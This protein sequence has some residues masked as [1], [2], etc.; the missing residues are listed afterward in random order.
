MLIPLKIVTEY[1]L[2]KSTIKINK[3]VKFLI[4]HNITACAI[5]DTNLY[6]VM[7]FYQEMTKNNLKPIIGL[8]VRVENY[9][10]YLY[11]KNANGY[12]NLLKIHTLKEKESLNFENL[13]SLLS[14]IKIVLP[15]E[16]YDLL[17]RFPNAYLSYKNDTEKIEALMNSEKSI[18]INPAH[19]LTKEN[20]EDLKYLEAI[21]KGI[22][23]KEVNTDY[24]SMYLKTNT[25]K[26]DEETSESFIS[27]IDIILENTS[28]YIPKFD[29]DIDSFKHLYN[30]TNKGLKKR[31]NNNVPEL[32]QK[33]LN[34]ELSVIK[35]MG[36]DDYFLIVYDYVLYAKKN[37]IL[38][39]P[40]RGSAAGSLVSYCL[41]ITD[42]DPIK[43]DLL[44]ERFL[45][46][47]RITMP[48][49]DIDFE[50]TKRGEVIEYVRKRYGENNVAPIM[51]FGTLGAKQV[52]RDVGRVLDMPLDLIDKFVKSLDA[53]L[54]LK[55][56][57]E[58]KPVHDFLKNYKELQKLYDIAYHLEGLKRHVST[59]AA[60]VV[61]SSIPL[62]EV[63]PI[64][65]NGEFIM[66]GLTME[67]LE[68]LGLLKMDFLALRNLTIISNVLE[69]I[70]SSTGKVL[71]LNRLNLNDKS[72]LELF[73]KGDTE[74]IFQYESSGMRNL[75]LKLKPTSFSDLVASVA[76]F[77]PGSMNQIDT[78][79]ARKYGKEK[80]TYLHKDLEP[81]LKETYGIIIYQEQ[82]MQILVKIGG[83][84]YAEAD[85]IRRAMSKKK[86]DIILNDRD[87]FIKEATKRGYEENIAKGIYD[88]IIPFAGY[89]FNKSH[90]VSYALIGYQMAYL[91]AKFP[92]YFITNLLNMSMGS[93]IKTKEY[94]D[95]ARKKDIII[96]KPNINISTNEYIIKDNSLLLP[97]SSIKNLG[98]NASTEILKER[99]NNGNFKDYIDFVTRVYGKSVNKKTIISLIDAGVL[100]SF[101]V[102]KKTMIENLDIVVNYAD[103]VESLDAAFCIPPALE[104]KEEYSEEELR[105][106]E[107]DSYGFY[108]TNHPISKY[109]DK[110]IV[111]LKEV[112]NYFDKHIKCVVLV[113][114]IKTVKTKKGDNMAFIT[115]SDETD[116]KD[117]VVFPLAFYMISNLK[118]GDIITLQGKVTKRFSEYQINIDFLNKI[119]E[120]N[121]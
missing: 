66:T 7:S 79:I 119:K 88:L 19:S 56:N 49:I 28:K 35:N 62:D 54:S 70:K 15:K 45:N 59:H 94:I 36:F 29:K 102:T 52:I 72:I 13:T 118:V 63:I 69:L 37:N 43:Y 14:N 44:F 3:L 105:L 23:L 25:T 83:Y 22:L 115:A 77:R 26:E 16:S 97:L 42:I 12:H 58:I 2:L 120:D 106:K 48:D 40:G 92:M 9:P 80:I 27:D 55:E 8:E 10:L 109:N 39:G 117:F 60:G 71:D 46:P 68:D 103:L 74:G 121:N 18:Y 104:I 20:A 91:K 33:R 11:A 107:H 116:S 93:I 64:Y 67:Y 101:N 17:D 6:G 61:I 89:G 98:I 73:S 50:Y 1:T 112:E 100:D 82:V 24:S 108:V 34:Y 111:K 51:T 96:L 90:S 114:R 113:E 57:L 81:I 5:C 95:E 86:Q 78:F 38:V 53:K 21:E 31:L 84:S 41:G 4:E 30:L 87:H 99:D 32:Y 75:M 65:Y 76:L 110:S 47:E 85:I